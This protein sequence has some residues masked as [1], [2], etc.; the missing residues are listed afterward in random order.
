MKLDTYNTTRCA[1][2]R[3]AGFGILEMVVVLAVIGIIA[4][5]L[6]M[7]MPRMLLAAKIA[8]ARQ[9]MRAYV[10]AVIGDPDNG[11]HGYI[12]DIGRLPRNV[13]DLTDRADHPLFNTDTT[14]K[15]GMGW[16]GPYLAAS[17]PGDDPVYD[18]W[19]TEYRIDDEGRIQSAGP[20]GEF[21]NL[22]DLIFPDTPIQ[23]GSSV[24][25]ELSQSGDYIVRLYYA[26]D[27]EEKLH[28]LEQ[29]PFVF[30]NV[31]R[32]PHAVEVW[33]VNKSE[34][35][36]ELVYRTIVIASPFGGT[37]RIEL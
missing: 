22:D 13:R 9:E 29:G 1:V 26:E 20:D 36:V 3:A 25:I 30:E 19:D 34:E 2:R 33:Q 32:G 10:R 24:R 35:K 23:V 12:G 21:D 28:Q 15:V 27:G 37:F 8:E 31:H 7:A 5:S 16:N 17:N 18:P 6:V 11:Y 14:Y 4:V